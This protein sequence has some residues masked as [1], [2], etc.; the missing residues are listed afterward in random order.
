MRASLAQDLGSES[1]QAETLFSFPEVETP[2]ISEHT[3]LEQE[4]VQTAR[5]SFKSMLKKQT[6]VS[7][8]QTSFSTTPMI[9][10][11]IKKS[12]N[13]V[14]SMQTVEGIMQKFKREH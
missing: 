5:E 3:L 13:S 2:E 14:N 6:R 1:N 12:P 4:A 8:G 11:P 9:P 7:Y 10:S